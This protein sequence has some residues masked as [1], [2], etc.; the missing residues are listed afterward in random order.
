MNFKKILLMSTL[1]LSMVYPSIAEA[2]EKVVNLKM[3]W[4]GGDDRHQ[5][6]LEA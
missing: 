1:C 4:W 6:T 3:S 5:K 2:K